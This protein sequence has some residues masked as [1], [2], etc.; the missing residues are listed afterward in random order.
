VVVG[1]HV[2]C[3]FIWLLDNVKL[4]G[5]V[6]FIGGDD[7]AIIPDTNYEHL[8]RYFRGNN[9]LPWSRRTE[10]GVMH[11]E[12]YPLER[13][14]INRDIFLSARQGDPTWTLPRK[15]DGEAFT[16]TNRAGVSRDLHVGDH[17][18]V[19]G[20]W[21][22]DHHPEYCKDPAEWDPPEPARC[23]N[24]GWLRVGRTHTELHPFD[25]KNIRLVEPLRAG[26]TSRCM[27]SMA[28]PLYEEQYWGD[29]KWFANELAGVS[30]HVF[31]D[32]TNYN[33]AVGTQIHLEAPPL[34]TITPSSYRRIAWNEAVFKIGRDMRADDVRSVRTTRDSIDVQV[35]VIAR[36]ENE[37]PPVPLGGLRSW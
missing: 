2:P 1:E 20:R 15:P 37:S 4:V 36:P 16:V 26:D 19:T 25:W 8:M 23:R 17:V 31:V 34:P 22:I 6:H 27:V 28:A 21:V 5:T 24:R 29:W 9:P 10:P 33:T 13:G 32:G 35:T 11:L 7:F 18:R 12:T 30:G 3:K 14:Q